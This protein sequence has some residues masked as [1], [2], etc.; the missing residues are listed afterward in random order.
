MIPFQDEVIHISILFNENAK[1]KA[2]LKV[3]GNAVFMIVGNSKRILWQY[4][5][6]MPP[7]GK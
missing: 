5:L 6:N 3:F 1:I 7:F 2:E 4:Q